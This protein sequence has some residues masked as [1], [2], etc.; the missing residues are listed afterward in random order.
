[1]RGQEIKKHFKY[2]AYFAGAATILAIITRIGMT[3]WLILVNN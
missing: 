1:M 3:S 2:A